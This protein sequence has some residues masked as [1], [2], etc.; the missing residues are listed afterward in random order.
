MN[1]LDVEVNPQ[2]V[3]VTVPVEKVGKSVPVKIKQEGT[4]E[5]DIE[6]SSMTPDKSEVVVVGDDAVL[7]KLK[8]LKFQLMFLKSKQIPSKK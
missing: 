2:E 1:K 4:P 5:S 6:I 8:K 3:E 7:E